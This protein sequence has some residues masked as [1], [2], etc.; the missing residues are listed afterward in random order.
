MDHDWRYLVIWEFRVS[1]GMEAMFEKH[2]GPGGTWVQLFRKGEGFIATELSRDLKEPGRYLT[3]D[4]WSSQGAYESFREQHA[5]RYKEIDAECEEMTESEAE[6][7]RFARVG[8][9]GQ[10]S[11]TFSMG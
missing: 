9:P 8:E 7:G 1:P 3:L 5:T 4:F 11:D 2:Y 6:I 10:K